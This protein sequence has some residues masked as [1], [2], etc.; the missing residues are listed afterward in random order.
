MFIQGELP[1]KING[2]E[3]TGVDV[4]PED[5]LKNQLTTFFNQKTFELSR[6]LDFNRSGV[7][8]TV[9]ACVTHLDHNPFTYRIF[10][11]RNIQSRNNRAT[12]RIFL[13]PRFNENGKRYSLS[14][15]RKLFFMLDLFTVQCKS[16]F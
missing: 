9:Q 8:G 6:G 11:N 15:Q 1:L 4:E 13:A 3:I 16:I 12:V 14:E 10:V 2:I 7:Q 5:G